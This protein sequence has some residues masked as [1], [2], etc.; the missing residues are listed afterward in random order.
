MSK[1]LDETLRHLADVNAM[2]LESVNKGLE[3]DKRLVEEW[4]SK[5]EFTKKDFQDMSHEYQIFTKYLKI[6][7]GFSKKVMKDKA[8]AKDIFT[9]INELS[10]IINDF[11]QV[12]RI[13][14]EQEAYGEFL[15]KIQR[16]LHTLKEG[17][18]QI[19]RDIN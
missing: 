7:V 6:V 1:E 11:K 17:A 4:V 5:E 9:E 10:Y 19:L 14:V 12:Q 18:E 13:D 3:I 2:L 16:D 8:I 15:K